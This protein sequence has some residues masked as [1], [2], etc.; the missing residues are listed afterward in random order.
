MDHRMGTDGLT[1]LWLLEAGL[2]P[3]ACCRKQSSSGA[4]PLAVQDSHP[5]P[6]YLQ[7]FGNFKGGI[8]S[9]CLFCVAAAAMAA[10]LVAVAVMHITLGDS[11]EQPGH[12]YAVPAHSQATAQLFKYHRAFVF[13][14]ESSLPTHSL[15]LSFC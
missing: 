13:T 12:S 1:S 5:P 7:L 2:H 9:F 6:L 15:I 10:V 3:R 8:V 4:N 14:W 11:G